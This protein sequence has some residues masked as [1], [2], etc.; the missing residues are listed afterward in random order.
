MNLKLVG[1]IM[2]QWAVSGQSFAQETHIMRAPEIDGAISLQVIA[3]LAGILFLM[4]R[5]K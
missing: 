4:K 2:L 3:L 5:K 1:T